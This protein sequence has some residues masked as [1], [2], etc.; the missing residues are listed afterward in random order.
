MNQTERKPLTDT[1][2]Q[3]FERI[4]STPGGY[5]KHYRR[6]DNAVCWKLM[7]GN[8]N[9][10]QLFGEGMIKKLIEKEYLVKK[11]QTVVIA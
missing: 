9:C 11:D 1:Q 3:A 10:I 5:L 4:R 7:D 6:H 8:H 2:E